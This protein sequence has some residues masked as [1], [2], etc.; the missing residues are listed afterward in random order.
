MDSIVLRQSFIGCNV[1]R[2]RVLR[3]KS[4]PGGVPPEAAHDH[5]V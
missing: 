2:L 5:R 1:V 3:M 4:S